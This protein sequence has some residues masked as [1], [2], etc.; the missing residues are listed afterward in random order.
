MSALPLRKAQQQTNILSGR[1]A[2]PPAI[3]GC[4]LT[5]SFLT[6]QVDIMAGLTVV[7]LPVPK[8]SWRPARISGVRRSPGQHTAQHR[9][10]SRTRKT[11][12][13][14]A[15]QIPVQRQSTFVNVGCLNCAVQQSLTELRRGSLTLH[16]TTTKHRLTYS[17]YVIVAFTAA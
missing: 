3:S 16:S 4:L 6:D 5:A 2:S 8:I 1:W 15:P 11:A 9:Q 13:S 12:R 17:M 14:L 10:L 7:Q